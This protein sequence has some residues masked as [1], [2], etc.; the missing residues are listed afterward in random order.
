M[1]QEL[2]WWFGIY[3]KFEVAEFDLE[4]A[5]NEYLLAEQNVIFDVISAHL[6]R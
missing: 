3:G 1:L 6:N 4:K 2:G 5:R